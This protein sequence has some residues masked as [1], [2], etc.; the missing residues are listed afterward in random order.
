MSTKRTPVSIYVHY[1]YHPQLVH[2]Q[3]NPEQVLSRLRVGGINIGRCICV[4]ATNLIMTARCS[5]KVINS[6]LWAFGAARWWHDGAEK[7]RRYYKDHNTQPS[8]LMFGS[9]AAA[10]DV[11]MYVKLSPS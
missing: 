3:A 6:G 8:L 4:S 5:S 9:G 1:Q 11:Y 7:I 10:F 2:A